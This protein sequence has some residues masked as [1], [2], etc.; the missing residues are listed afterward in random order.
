MCGSGDLENMAH[1]V[2]R[3]S[4]ISLSQIL[5]LVPSSY[6]RRTMD[7]ESKLLAAVFYRKT[8]KNVFSDKNYGYFLKIIAMISRSCYFSYVDGPDTRFSPL[9][10]TFGVFHL[11]KYELFLREQSILLIYYAW[12]LLKHD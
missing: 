7:I 4:V 9:T 8:K 1:T 5:F 12:P 3:P 6:I 10:G 11:V 2:I